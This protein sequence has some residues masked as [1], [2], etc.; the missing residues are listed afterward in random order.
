M[1]ESLVGC[2]SLPFVLWSF[3][4]VCLDEFVNCCENVLMTGYIFKSI[5][6]ILFDPAGKSADVIQQVLVVRTMGDCL[7]LQLGD[8]LRFSC[9]WNW[10]Y[11][12]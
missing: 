9:P 3:P 12:S 2:Q 1:R 7:Q 5:W 11:P 6:A 10:C 4:Y 8:L